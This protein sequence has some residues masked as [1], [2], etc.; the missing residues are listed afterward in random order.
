MRRFR[1]RQRS[2]MQSRNVDKIRHA[3]NTDV[4]KRMLIRYF[5]SKGFTESFDRILHPTMI[6]DL[7]FAIPAIS[8]KVEVVPHCAEIDPIGRRA[9]LGWNLFALGTHRMFLGE[10]F[11]NDLGDLARQIQTGTI[12]P[13]SNQMI[14]P[15]NGDV[16]GVAR[17]QVTPRQV[18]TF[19]TRVLGNHASGYIDLTSPVQTP[20]TSMA[21][22]HIGNRINISGGMLGSGGY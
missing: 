12:N 14:A 9:V 15:S 1:V 18:I 4:I 13:V 17:R 19:L 7:A 22:N 11:H 21:Y 20:S 8:T 5:I 10:T 3:L 16:N 2:H 6:Q